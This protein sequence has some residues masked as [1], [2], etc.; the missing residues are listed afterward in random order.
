MASP[1]SRRVTSTTYLYQ[2]RSNLGVDQEYLRVNITK[3]ALY[4][5][6]IVITE[7]GSRRRSGLPSTP[8]DIKYANISIGVIAP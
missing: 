8:L 4:N 5:D 1:S 3:M 7:F 6:I 2:L